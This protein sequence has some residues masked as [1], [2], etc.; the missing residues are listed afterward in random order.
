MLYLKHRE[1]RKKQRFWPHRF[2]KAVSAAF[3]IDFFNK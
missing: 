2:W 3:N 1:E